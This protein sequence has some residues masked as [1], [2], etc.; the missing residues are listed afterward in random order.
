MSLRDY[1]NSHYCLEASRRIELTNA[2]GLPL[3]IVTLL[4]SGLA[5]ILQAIHFPLDLTAILQLTLVGLALILVLITAYLLGRSYHSNYEYG[6]APTAL[7]LRDFKVRL[8]AYYVS[9]GDVPGDADLKAETE[10]VEH[11]ESEFAVHAHRNHRNNNRKSYFLFL[12]NGTLLAAILSTLVAG[13][14][15]LYTSITGAP[16]IPIVKVANFAE[17]KMPNQ[18]T[19]PP[20]AQTPSTGQTP[21]GAPPVKPTPPPGRLI[22][23]HVNPT[24]KT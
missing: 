13:A 1:Y 15:F 7:E 24:K 12:A 22:K 10:A 11:L 3:G 5:V 20:P 9:L 16:D 21:P 19:S 4:V 14:A 18:P 2:L 6:Y 17:I 23:E 8:G